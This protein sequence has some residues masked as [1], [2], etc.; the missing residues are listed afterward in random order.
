MLRTLQLRHKFAVLGVIG[1]ISCAVPLHKVIDYKNGE[2]AVARA[3][4]QGI[5][6]VRKALALQRQLQNHRGLSGIVLNGQTASEPE[7][8]ASRA[9]IGAQLQA[10]IK[11]TEE[12]AYPKAQASLVALKAGWGPLSQKVDT[13]GLKPPESFAAHTALIQSNL[14][15]M[16]QL[17]DASSLSLDPVAES[18][19][20]MTAVIDHLPRLAEALAQ[21]RGKG[22]AMLASGTAE[23]IDRAGLQYLSDQV[24]Y[25][26][27][28]AVGQMNKAA[29]L[30][31]DLGKSLAPVQKEANEAADRF[32]NLTQAQLLGT[33]A[34]TSKA[35]DFFAAGSVALAAQYKLAEE[36]ASAL[37]RL[38]DDRVTGG[39]HDRNML[40]AGMAALAALALACA[41]M[42]VSSV[43]RPTRH[44][45]EAANAVASGDLAFAIDDAGRD[46]AAVLLKQFSVMQA[47][48]H[49]RR[50]EDEE[51]LH[52][53]EA[54]AL[55]TTQ[56]AREIGVAVDGATQGDF[57]HRISLDGKQDFHVE[58]CSKFNLLIETVS[59]TIR[60]VRTAADELSNA[61]EQVNQTSQ[62]LSRLASQQAANLEET[63]ASLQEMSGSIQGNANSAHVTDE[64]ANQAATQA[65]EGSSAVSQTVD[66]MKSIAT[67]ISIIDDIAYQTNLLALNAAIEAARAGEHG[68]GF[69]VVAAEV[70]KLAERSQVAAQEIG[71]LAT[72]SVDTAESAGQA[73][74]QMLP[75]IARTSELVQDIAATSGEQSQSV[76]Q[77]N[78][79]MDHLNSAAQQ[80]ASASEELSSTAEELL[81]QA[82]QLQTLMAYFRLDDGHP[83]GPASRRSAAAPVGHAG[84]SSRAQRF[85]MS[86]AE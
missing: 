79:A 47:S 30:Q 35:A 77:I 14:N 15:L 12:L 42:V 1:A 33:A 53:T 67:K 48:L 78:G 31:P 43:T 68:K 34:P 49:Q 65:Q 72:A 37:Q 4:L 55:A 56:L 44:A 60:E 63:T 29:E 69:A 58:L 38:L 41:Y 36:A 21:V 20:V 64:M 10:L 84:S 51:R 81:A 61:S 2:I 80:T 17:A 82:G 62:S 75:S 59:K 50:R 86:F 27:S 11:Q 46:E 26:R 32:V 23:P 76:A 24:S 57:T 70:R 74:S 28:R 18:Y 40:L 16:D 8:Q 3:E 6:P 13:Q 85:K 45:I 52:A 7:R 19:Y 9:D 5:E 73:L 22:A 39:E 66:A 71:A 83:Q 54:A 25:L